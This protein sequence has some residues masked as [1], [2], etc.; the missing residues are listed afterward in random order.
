VSITQRTR[1]VCRIAHWVLTGGILSTIEV[2]TQWADGHVVVVNKPAGVPTHRP[3]PAIVGVVERLE[4]ELGEKLG[5]H[6]RLDAATSGVL[7]F[8]RSKDA[9]KSLARTFE[10]H[11]G[12]KHYLAVVIGRPPLGSGLLEHQLSKTPRDGRILVQE[13]EGA[14]ALSRYKVLAFAGPYT[15]CELEPITGRTHQLRVQMAAIGCP[16]LGDTLYGGGVGPGRMLLHAWTLRIQHPVDGAVTFKAAPPD[17]MDPASF[18]LVK[19][20]GALLEH[21]VAS[22]PDKNK[23]DAYS[24]ATPDR[25]GLADV[26]LERYGSVAAIRVYERDLPYARIRWSDL[27]LA[28]LGEALLERTWC[29]GAWVIRHPLHSA[30][31]APEP[32][33]LAF[34]VVP[35]APYCV[36]EEGVRYEIS[37]QAGLGCGLYL[38][39]G[40]N[41][42]RVQ[43][44]AS[45]RN[46]LNLF[47]Y[48]CAFSVAA[49]VGGASGTT[50]VD[51]S[52]AALDW[53]RRNFE[54]NGLE[55]GPHRFYKDDV[56]AV[57]ERLKRRGERFGL[58]ICD[59]PSF[60]RAGKRTFSLKKDL[61][62]LMQACLAV[63]EPGGALLFCVNHSELSGDLLRRVFQACSHE[64]GV[65]IVSHSLTVGEGG[66]L[67]VGTE[68][69]SLWAEVG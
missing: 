67:A 28:T 60:G 50:S 65:D 1:H 29:E 30:E 35:A 26:K 23:D 33:P 39:Q 3:D 62:D 68:L 21:N 19:L 17:L 9:A 5:V 4:A 63:V 40:E 32:A 6:H 49:A 47:S 61:G 51:S 10:S 59:P 27:D 20:L 52:K 11:S 58:V 55:L 42:R 34:G 37:L 8:S 2:T 48:T 22:E 43:A 44:L 7:V 69:K 56:M 18:S 57:L 13:S 14:E 53:G 36:G 66:P 24:L 31:S 45:Q 54:A 64:A 41:R 25:S 16:I 46:V 15:L 12:G 38:D